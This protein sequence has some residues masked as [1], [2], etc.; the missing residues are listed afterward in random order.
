MRRSNPELWC[1]CHGLLR[2][3]RNDGLNFRTARC[4]EALGGRVVGCQA[5][6][7][8]LQPVAST[9]PAAFSPGTGFFTENMLS[10]SP[11]GGCASPTNTVLINWWSP[12]RYSGAPGCSAISGGSLKPASARA[13]FGASS[14]FSWFAITASVCTEAKPN[15]L[16]AVA[17]D[18]V[19]FLIAALNSATCGTPG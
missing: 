16:R 9:G 15:Q 5:G 12:A 17:A 3:A 6:H 14:V 8:I 11:F 18:P 1:P 13:S 2:F 7:W 10:G 19:I 4:V